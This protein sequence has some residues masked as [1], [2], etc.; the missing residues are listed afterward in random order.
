YTSL[1]NKGVCNFGLIVKT[2]S[3]RLDGK[4]TPVQAMLNFTNTPVVDARLTLNIGDVTFKPGDKIA[5]E[6]ILVPFGDHDVKTDHSVHQV[7]SDSVLEPYKVNV[8]VGKLLY[9]TYLPHV[10][11]VD[12]QAE[13]T[14]DGGLN[15]AAVRVDGFKSF[16]RPKVLVKNETGL[17]VPLKLS[18]HD[19]DGIQS[20][21][22]ADGSYG[23]SFIVNTTDGPSTIK[24]IQ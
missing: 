9:D 14:I 20:Y 13:F 5:Y 10:Q 3:L 1:Y 4:E 17:F 11:A 8:I 6:L 16:T 22:N 2:C 19:Y 23:F 24:V 18:Y 15:N 12:Q 7:R 21:L